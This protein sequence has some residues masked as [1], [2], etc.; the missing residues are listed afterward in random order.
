MKDEPWKQRTATDTGNCPTLGE[1]STAERDGKKRD[2]E[3][4]KWQ[5]DWSAIKATIEYA[6]KTGRLQRQI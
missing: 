4:N 3:K 1:Y 5:P 2:G 6:I